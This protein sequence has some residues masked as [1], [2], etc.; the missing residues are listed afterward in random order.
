LSANDFPSPEQ[1]EEQG[2]RIGKITIESQ[3]IFDLDN[4][5]ENKSFYRLANKLHV[6][7]RPQVIESQLL[8]AEGDTYTLRVVEESERLLRQNVY[9]R[10]V[11]IEPVRIEDGAIDLQ[12]RTADV[13]SL[14][15]SV[16]AGRE[17]GESRL[18]IG[19]RERNLFGHG[20]Y[21]GFKY[22][23]TVDRDT[24]TL[25]FADSH[26]RGTRN[27]VS[28]RVGEN[29]DGHDYRLAFAKPFF[30][31]DSRQSSGISL[32]AGKLTESLYSLG[33]IVSD[34][35]HTAQHHEIFSG[36]SAGLND[37]W[38]RRFYAGFVYDEHEFAATPD[39]VF[40][41]TLV[42]GDRKYVYPYVGFETV[43]DHFVES[44]NFD[45][46]GRVEDRFLGTRFA[47]RV[48]YAPTAFGS[49]SDAWHYRATFNNAL[50][51]SKRTSLTVAARLDGRYEAGAAT[52]QWI[53][54]ETRFHRRLTEYQLFYASLTN[55]IGNKLD[56][57]NPLLIGG[58]SGLR[59]YPLRYQGGDSKALLTLEQRFFTDWYPWRL[60]NV[61]AAIFFDA[62]RTWGQ[63]PAGGPNVG[64]LR[65]AGVGLRLGN[66]RAGD[67]GVLHID[68]AFPLDGEDDLDRFQILVDLRSGF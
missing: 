49:S 26:F 20:M 15:P 65:D 2:V 58:D 18:G 22:K 36:W 5:H 25:D 16:T 50:L 17:G 54:L 63:N 59:G 28:F 14:T 64:L 52:N 34:F 41:I 47:F 43:Q 19:I 30:A 33:D 61:G 66:N 39:T 38:V 29:S 48:G 62:G 8:F 31:L 57:D 4:P 10:E 67:G 3:N 11:D 60:F 7:T 37:G 45:Q 53:S 55:S 9:L 32:N 44:E 21:L 13:W 56:L 12:V 42:P 6:V 23:S 1:L 35:Q 51:A 68:F 24:S 46:I 40:P 27:Q